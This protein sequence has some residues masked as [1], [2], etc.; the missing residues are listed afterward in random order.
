MQPAAPCA[1]ADRLGVALAGVLVASVAFVFVALVAS[2]ALAAEPASAPQGLAFVDVG[3]K[4]A[5]VWSRADGAGEMQVEARRLSGAAEPALAA[6]VGVGPE[7]DF[8]GHVVL[9]GLAPATEYEVSVRHVTPAG[10]A[11]SA[12]GRLRTAP[13]RSDAAAVKLAFGGD[14]GGQNVC[15]DASTGYRIFRTLQEQKPDLFV[16]L[17]DMI[18]ADN[19]C[20]AEGRYGN[21]Q[22]AGPIAPAADVE[23][24]RSRWRYN[25][26]DPHW[27]ALAATTPYVPV[28]DDHEVVNDFGP[29]HDTPAER[30]DV[31][32][33]RPGLQ[34]FLEYNPIAREQELHRALRWGR[35]LELLVLDTRQHRDS[36]ARPDDFAAPKTLLGASQRA[37]LASAFTISD[38]T[39]TVVVSSVPISIPTGALPDPARGRDGWAD[40]DQN[41]GFEGELRR[42]L[43][44]ALDAG[45]KNLVWI[46]TDAHVAAVFRYRPFR[47]SPGFSFHEVVSGPL[48]AMI[49]DTASFDPSFDPERLFFH[50]PEKIDAITSWEMAQGFLNFGTLAIDAQGVLTIGIV[51]ARGETLYTQKLEPRP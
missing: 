41:T 43:I 47:E 8:S 19:P 17:G 9:T 14:V 13:K 10:V 31:H 7:T 48:N 28:W 30:P 50:A 20:K 27:Q 51:N 32:L 6:S 46:T 38:A 4:S 11:S 45:V 49:G 36:N 34:A 29:Q 26:A 21:A 24:F 1:A 42:V 23:G 37:W 35:H 3:D 39:W 40:F 5:V 16:G 44:D 12:R 22:L 15:R 18:Y 25:R 33:L 2:A